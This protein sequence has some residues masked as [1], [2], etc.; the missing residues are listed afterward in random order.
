[1][2]QRSNNNE[3]CRIM[4]CEDTSED[5]GRGVGDAGRRSSVGF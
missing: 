4:K 5:E 3:T 2:I 1:M